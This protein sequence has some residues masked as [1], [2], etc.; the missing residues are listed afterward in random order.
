[1]FECFFDKRKEGQPPK[2]VRLMLRLLML[3]YIHNLSDEEVVSRWVE[4]PYR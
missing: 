3:E 2:P 4:N 1:M